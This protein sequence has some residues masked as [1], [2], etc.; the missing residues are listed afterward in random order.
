[1]TIKPTKKWTAPIITTPFGVAMQPGDN[2]DVSYAPAIEEW[3]VAQGYAKVIDQ[4][5]KEPKKEKAESGSA[6]APAVAVGGS[7]DT[8]STNTG[9]EAPPVA[10]TESD[11]PPPP[12]NNRATKKKSAK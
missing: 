2:R 6:E 7:A 3:L 10:S 11:A 8:P 4:S 9:S 12:A 1:M 5:P